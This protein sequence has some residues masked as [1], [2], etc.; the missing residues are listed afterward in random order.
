MAE[1]RYL[2]LAMVEN[3]D[4]VSFSIQESY[5]MV[6][7]KFPPITLFDDMMDAKDFGTAYA[8]QALTNP[9]ILNELDDLTLIPI[10]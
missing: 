5:R 6:N 8:L 3:Q 10:E 9:R 7:S 1:P 2:S 4:R